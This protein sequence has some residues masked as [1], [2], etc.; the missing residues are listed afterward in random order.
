MTMVRNQVKGR[1]KEVK[2]FVKEVAGKLTGN[3]ALEQRGKVQKIRGAA[4]AEIADVKQHV[5]D[6]KKRG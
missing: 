3:A 1:V 4:Q 6:A 2:G 5:K